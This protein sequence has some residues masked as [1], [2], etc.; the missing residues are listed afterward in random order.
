MIAY[1]VP[2]FLRGQVITDDLVA[3][4]TRTGV[5]QF[6]VSKPGLPPL[7]YRAAVLARGVF[8]NPNGAPA[9]EESVAV[10]GDGCS[11]AGSSVTLRTI[12]RGRESA[13]AR[14]PGTRCQRR[15]ERRDRWQRTGCSRNTVAFFTRFGGYI[16][17]PY[18]RSMPA[19]SRAFVASQ[20]HTS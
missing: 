14:A 6:R 15:H 10:G 18:R 20:L 8:Q 9:E 11:G 1:T 2:L 17:T 19:K 4:E 13:A 5:A 16:R 7:K 3:F 12:R